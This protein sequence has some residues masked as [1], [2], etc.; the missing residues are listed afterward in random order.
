MGCHCLLPL[1][2][3]RHQFRGCNLVAK[4]PSHPSEGL[5]PTPAWH[6]PGSAPAREPWVRVPFSLF[7]HLYPCRP[8]M[9]VCH[10][11]S[12][13]TSCPVTVLSSVQDP[14]FELCV[15]LSGSCLVLCNPLDCSPP[16]S[17]V[18]GI[19]HARILEW[20][21]MPS[22]RGI[23]PT[24]RSNLHLFKSPT[25]SSRFIFLIFFTTSISCLALCLPA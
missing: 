8:P 19:L 14:P 11:P 10:L 7:C 13:T 6:G 15:S 25:F 22:S 21:A 16:G 4:V 24:E 17:S 1:A 20:V 23:F 5:L 9:P 12:L 3:S 2:L 18:H